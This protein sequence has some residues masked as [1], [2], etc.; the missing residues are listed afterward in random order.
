MKEYR[1]AHINRLTDGKVT[2]LSSLVYTDLLNYYRRIKDHT[3]NIAEVAAGE[4]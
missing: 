3:L 1:Q 2:P 4:K